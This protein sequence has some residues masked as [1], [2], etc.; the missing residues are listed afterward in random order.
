LAAQ[1]V[2]VVVLPYRLLPLVEQAE[3]A[4]TV[5]AEEAEE[6]PVW[7]PPKAVGVDMV[8]MERFMFFHGKKQKGETYK[9]QEN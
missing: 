5:E 3:K 4:V 8:V 2:A 7:L 1:V 6:E 9:W